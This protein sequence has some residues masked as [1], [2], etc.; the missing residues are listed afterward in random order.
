MEPVHIVP[1]G[2]NN[3]RACYCGKPP[4]QGDRYDWNYERTWVA[5]PQEYAYCPEC[6][7]AAKRAREAGSVEFAVAGTLKA[8]IQQEIQNTM[9]E[10]KGLLR[11]LVREEIRAYF[12]ELAK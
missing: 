5:E 4:P 7:A 11:I 8:L 1:D 2:T 10:D 6:V 3:Y 12:K 9:D